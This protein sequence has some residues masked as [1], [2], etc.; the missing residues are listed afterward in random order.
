MLTCDRRKFLEVGPSS[1]V[2]N[3]TD[4]LSQ[5]YE[6]DARIGHQ[7]FDLKLTE[8][9]KMSMVR[10]SVIFAPRRL[11]FS[12]LESLSP[13]LASGLR[14]FEHSRHRSFIYVIQK[15]SCQRIQGW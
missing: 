15:I 2:L 5:L 14:E 4:K 6:D 10:T 12:R 11:M 9:V 3:G 13:P 1:H 7:Q 8:R